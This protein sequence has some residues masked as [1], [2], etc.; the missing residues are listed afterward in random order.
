MK[1]GPF[2]TTCAL[3]A[4]CIFIWTNK[5][6]DDDD[7]DELTHHCRCVVTGFILYQ[8]ARWSKLAT[9]FQG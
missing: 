7:D 8:L 5:D 9:I 6:D 4:S 2:D 3:I 1:T